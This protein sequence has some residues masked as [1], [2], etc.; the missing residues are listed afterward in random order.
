MTRYIF[1]ADPRKLHNIHNTIHKT[2]A[3]MYTIYTYAY[4]AIEKPLKNCI[5]MHA[6]LRGESSESRR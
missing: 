4:I 1:K 3:Y 2:L 5:S 6:K